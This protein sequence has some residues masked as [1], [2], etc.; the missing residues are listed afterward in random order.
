MW[1][2]GASFMR[3]EIERK[4]RYDVCGTGDEFGRWFGFES[5]IPLTDYENVFAE[6]FLSAFVLRGCSGPKYD[7]RRADHAVEGRG[8]YWREQ[9]DTLGGLCGRGARY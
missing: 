6:L 5:A 7:N 8:D 3:R 1:E 4:L 9:Y 2:I